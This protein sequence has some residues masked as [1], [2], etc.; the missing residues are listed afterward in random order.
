VWDANGNEFVD[1]HAAFGA[2]LLGHNDPEVAEAVVRALEEHG[3]TFATANVLEVEL[4][5]RI[6]SM[7]PSAERAVF[8]CTGTEATYHAIRLARAVTGRRTVLKLEGHYHGW[9]DYA[10]WSV[11][12]DPADPANQRADPHPIAGSAGIPPEVGALMIVREYNDAAGIA[13][14]VRESAKDGRLLV[15]LGDDSGRD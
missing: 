12:F 8:S 9:H 4:A 5:E 11:H 15:R 7:V 2:V 3:V 13:D 6:V 14:A 1:F 10:A